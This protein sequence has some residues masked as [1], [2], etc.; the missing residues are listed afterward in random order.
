MNTAKK[1]YAPKGTEILLFPN[2]AYYDE[3]L[4]VNKK[5]EKK[6]KLLKCH[7]IPILDIPSSELKS[8]TMKDTLSLPT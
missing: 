4:D 7:W 1:Q 3:W 5:S 8:M 2:S 6:R